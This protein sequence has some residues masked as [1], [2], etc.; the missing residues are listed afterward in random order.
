MLCAVV[1]A[2]VSMRSLCDEFKNRA[3]FASVF[4]TALCFQIYSLFK[5]VDLVC[6]LIAG[7]PMLIDLSLGI[8]PLQLEVLMKELFSKFDKGEWVIVLIYYSLI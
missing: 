3:V 4:T 8:S 7:Q 1:R 6:L 5:F 2:C